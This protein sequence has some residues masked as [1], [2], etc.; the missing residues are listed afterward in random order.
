MVATGQRSVGEKLAA[1]LEWLRVRDGEY[2]VVLSF[3]WPMIAMVVYR[4]AVVFTDSG[5][6]Y[7][8]RLDAV[9]AHLKIG[10]KVPA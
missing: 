1:L 2:E 5:P 7:E 8:A 3:G 9:L 10:A 6:D 4:D